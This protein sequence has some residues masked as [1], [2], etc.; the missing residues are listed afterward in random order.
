MK[1]IVLHFVLLF[2][3]GLPHAHI[4]VWLDP[5]DAPKR[6]EDIDRFTCAELPDKETSPELHKLVKTHMMHGPCEGY[7][8][9]GSKGPPCMKNGKCEKGFP[10][11]FCQHTLHGEQVS[12]QYRRRS[13]ADGGHEA[14]IYSSY[15]KCNY[16][17]NNKFVVPNNR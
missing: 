15:T 1:V 4:A 2:F 10:K 9:R 12:P 8:P 6:P 16:K 5:R 17:L 13:P 3:R 7:V 11:D 14:H